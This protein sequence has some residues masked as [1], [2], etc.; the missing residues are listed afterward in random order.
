MEYKFKNRYNQEITFK[1]EGDFFEMSGGDYYRYLFNED[2][3]G[4][5]AIDPSGGPFISIGMDMEYVH[6]DL[7][8]MVIKKIERTEDKIILKTN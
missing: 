7:K 1:K 2:N 5:Y 3:N 6:Q 8:G 4:Y